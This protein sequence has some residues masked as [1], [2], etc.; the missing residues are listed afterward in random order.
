MLR[1]D[2]S[3]DPSF[4]DLVARVRETDLAAYAHQDV[5]FERLVE[6]LSPDRSLA[7]HPLFQVSLEFQNAA[8]GG[9]WE[10]PGLTVRPTRSSPDSAR[11][12][13]SFS[14]GE[15][16]DA[17]GAPGGIEGAIRYS[18]DLFD[19]E[20]A[21]R[22]AA[23][24]TRV[25]ET[26]AADP[27]ARL[28]R[29]GVMD[30]A[31]HRQ[32]V[33]DWNRTALPVPART[34]PEAF[35]ARVA[36]RPDGVA[37][38]FEG[39]A[40]SYADLDAAAN[41]L[42]WHLIGQGV[43][44]EQLVAVAMPRSAEMVV[45]LLAVAKAGAGFVPIDPGYPA[46][47]VTFMLADA[48]PSAVVCT[49][50]V[51]RDLPAG[52]T[53]VLLDDDAVRRALE[54]CP[55]HAPRDADR[56]R[57]LRPAHPAYVIYTSGSTGRPKGVTVTHTGIE[58]LAASQIE[59]FAVGP[60]SRVLQFAS[61]SFDAS[62]WEL[63]MALLSG[64]GLVV[65]GADRLGPQGSLAKVAGDFGVTHAT[66]P[67]ALVSALPEDG[68]GA[69]ETVVVAGE[70]CPPAL[71]ERWSRGRRL[72]NA[73]G[74]TEVTV[75]AAMTA[76][77]TPDDVTG[78]VVPIGRPLRNARVFVLDAYLTPVPPGVT[79]EMYVAG[80]GLARGYRDRFALT[81][82]RF[83]ACPFGDPG[84]RMYRTGDLARWTPGGDLVFA[85][86]ADAQVKVRGFRVEP[87]EIEAVLA[88]HPSVTQAAVVARE[89]QPGQ[90]Q[91][92]AYVVPEAVDGAVLRE[93]VAATLPEYMV[94]AAVV[95]LAALPLTPSG[96]L[97]R[98]A[99][100]APDFGGPVTSRE[101]RTPMEEVVCGLF[102]E[103]LGLERVGADDGFFA[104]GGDSLLAV[105]LIARI[106]SVLG[107]EMNI[108]ALF[109][110]PTAAGVALLVEAGGQARPP[111]VAGDRPDVLPLSFGQL[112]MWFLNRF[113]EGA[114]VYNV[115]LG[116]RLSGDLDQGALQAALDDVTRRHESLRTIFP[117]TDGVP[118]Q[119]IVDASPELV[120]IETDE[121]RLTGQMAAEARRG[122]DVGAEL[123]LRARLFALA[124]DEHVL[125]LVAH[126]IAG[127]GWS[128]GVLMR[129]LS[130]AY[131]ARQA[132]QE[133]PW[134]PL[135]V[136]YADFA[137][138]QRETLGAEED[139]GS[140]ISAQLA[141]WRQALA[142]LPAELT[143][144]ADRPR[145]PVAS[146]RGGSVPLQV[147]AE[148]HARL[149]ELARTRHA[150][151]FM[152]VQTAIAALLSRLG[153][154]E[155]IPIGV[156]VAGRGDA[157]L[158]DLIGFF[159][160]TLVLRTDVSGD[161]SFTDLVE[162]VREASLAAYAHQDVPFERLV[163]ELSPARS[164]AR[165]PL[166]QVSLT[167]QN[168]P[169]AASWDLAGLRV[170]P[171]R[172]GGGGAAKFDLSF[173][174]GE[175][176]DDDGAPAGLGGVLD[177]SADLF[178][179]PTAERLAER[180]VRLLE[181]V[182]ADP[183][184]RV[185][186]V[187]VLEEAERRLVVEE[188]NR[189]AEQVASQAMPELFEA[190]AAATPDAVAVMFEDTALTYAELDAAANRLAWHLIGLG[191]GPERLVA[192]ALPRTAEL[193]VAL[194]AVLKAGAGYVPVDPDYPAARVEFMLA[195]A[196]PACLVTT[197]EAAEGLPGGVTTVVLG[198]PDV[199]A[200]PDRAPADAD[201]TAPLTGAHPAYVIY[202]SGSTGTPKGVLVPHRNVVSL[203][204]SAGRVFDLG[205]GDVWSLFHSYAFDFS[206]W[207]LWG[208]LL[209]GG[210]VVVVPYA[211]SRSP[212]EFLG[213]V[214]GEGVT[215]LSQT[216]SAFYQLMRAEE[217]SMAEAALRYVVF[218]GEALEPAR[219]REWQGRHPAPVLVNM[220]GITET[221][222]HVTYVRLDREQAGSVVGRPLPNTRVFVLDA[223]LRPVPPG[224]VGEMYVAGAGLARGYKDR[225]GLTAER[226]VACPFGASGERMYRTGDLARWTS[227]GELV[228]AGRADAQ[229]KIRGFRV[230][231]GEV[232]AALAGH[233]SV[234]QV[235]VIARQDRPGHRRLVAYVVP[236]GD[237][238][239]EA[240]LR[241][242]AAGAL[243]EYMVPAAVV[244]VPELPLTPSGKLD[245]AAL[246][247]PDF[248]GQVTGREP[249]TPEERAMCELFAEV[250]G[251]DRVGADD[252]FFDL[253]GDS[254]LALRLIARIRAALETKVNVR[255][256]FA[257]PT[258]AGLAA[259][260]EAGD[261]GGDYDVL[262]PL[263]ARGDRP[264]LFC[265][266]PVEGIG[267]RYAG[268]ADHLPDRPIYGLQ[269]RGLARPDEPLPQT[270]EE[271]AADYFAQMRTVQPEGP[272][273]LLGWS[274]G[275]VI[276]HAVATHIQEQGEQVALLAILD[277]YPS[278]AGRKKGA[279]PA[280][281]DRGR[282][283]GE[284][285][286]R[287]ERMVEEIVELA[288]RENG[289][290]E[291]DAE[292]VSAIRATLINNRRLGASFTPGRF[293][294]DVLLFV[295]L[296]GRPPSSP[297]AE[298]PERWRPYVDGHI[299]SRDLAYT[300]QDLVTPASFAEV[301]RV[302]S[303]RPAGS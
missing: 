214:A 144:P 267:W 8:R 266:H 227:E 110:S 262:L 131:T 58:S 268:L 77:L 233:P 205:A 245:R 31:E 10:L 275:G 100:P 128:M 191:V 138:W 183:D 106:R 63:C 30:E 56:T 221:T 54:E 217:E 259:S 261:E 252:G 235:A 198:D 96:K 142:E 60:H 300:H 45:A 180:L 107:V 193:V 26:V 89:D 15:R 243:P 147:G 199:A 274:L 297:A 19:R 126:H 211:V 11:F 185:S 39:R 103:V 136:Q 202:T 112:R 88:A 34:L 145:P 216:P 253:G 115:P 241:E 75:C 29:I 1:T 159:V 78:G 46:A 132:G 105:R 299:E 36:E 62:V 44:P 124:P 92:V 111:L 137:V 294:G 134:T 194:L 25:L 71:V 68:L 97:D 4:A 93:S 152:V 181:T 123:P 43:G 38:V 160:N 95:P 229:V 254:L 265:V 237:G 288:R 190:R 98:A 156:P 130:A 280:G 113:Q 182:A 163:E 188:W 28:S 248:A 231:P 64:A 83:V 129:D 59:A 174:V 178:D 186:Q 17:G 197:A 271:M 189:T 200:C 302:I 119:E 82:E 286:E 251:L 61:P 273:H 151:M 116:L 219:L 143:L 260:L 157:A 79:G 7:R 287:L 33:E 292:V 101:A 270:M 279:A 51:A 223:L 169:R 179:R 67:P 108:R 52:G 74:P 272:Y 125:M 2:V 244:A 170:R 149:V 298:A 141:H 27:A 283:P 213:L 118:R 94:P 236:A 269:A 168:A 154:G 210:R 218:G 42:A 47:R 13:L 153:A 196:A 215:V 207:E 35:E 242:F 114:A 87:G 226:F 20:T 295:S 22:L 161:P 255:A 14:L 276:A 148:T 301:A 285:D 40:L 187:E 133:P 86:R 50:R 291:V 203:V 195:D 176:R 257:A 303:E 117:D 250:L 281:A 41:R 84:R 70:E 247:V 234:G 155:D 12:D 206:V 239:D 264:P 53:R 57:P 208:A 240:G 150:T 246:P 66:L 282:A 278:F 122:F 21:E 167:F 175:R 48:A 263:R 65:V 127:D 192:V 289:R 164:L 162:R 73:Y 184:V 158:D 85:G 5:P 165:H 296:L 166:F 230:E 91:L 6:E 201:R 16:R 173:S 204:E 256:L 258:P 72:V 80:A 238:A 121:E 140:L 90:K 228:F 225:A 24:L 177:Y 23:W 209:L 220:Y 49:E 249:R 9:T 32:V 55:D 222:V 293:H 102:A 277:G 224:V 172:P 99:L 109:G 3:G 139:A 146:Y 120:V 104:L 284:T 212:Q 37:V 18:K 290:A 171:V 232:E 76:P 69:M 135:P 81:A